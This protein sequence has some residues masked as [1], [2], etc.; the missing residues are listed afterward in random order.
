MRSARVALA[1]FPFRLAALAGVAALLSGCASIPFIGGRDREET[2][3]PPSAPGEVQA[4][5]PRT[6]A[7]RASDQM[8]RTPTARRS[9]LDQALGRNNEPNVGPCPF[10]RVLYDA[11]RFVRLDGPE[12][13]SNVGFTGEITNVTATC[14]YVGAQPIAVALNMD[15]AFGKGPKAAGDRVDAV[16]WV[17]VTRR[18]IAPLARERFPISATFPAGAAR[19]GVSD[20]VGQIVIP[21]ANA[22]ISGSNFEI[23]VGFELPPEQLA[24]NRDGKRFRVDAGPPN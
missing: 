20:T 23:L 1:P 11:S 5:A 21:R 9:F 4:P 8:V 16:Y 24:F 13:Y 22:D 12:L 10:V 3:P 19:V 18:D 6:T 17:A 7:E 14:R 15:F 2:P